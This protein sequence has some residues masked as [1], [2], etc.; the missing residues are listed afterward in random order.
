[1]EQKEYEQK[2]LT[3]KGIKTNIK[4]KPEKRKSS[5]INNVKDYLGKYE[6]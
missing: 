1:M 6:I 4:I 2:I 5:N 3:K